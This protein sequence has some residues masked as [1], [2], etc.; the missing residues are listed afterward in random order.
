MRA[1][2]LDQAVAFFRRAVQSDP[3]KTEYKIALGRAMLAASYAHLERAKELEA[4]EQL[5][6]ARGEYRLASEYDPSN[7]S[8]AAKVAALDQ[9]IRYRAEA[10]RPRPPIDDMRARAADAEPCHRLGE[11]ALLGAR[12]CATF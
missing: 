2:N 6:A 7:R 11:S 10:A 1:G 3:D 5:E 9:I 4:Q 8:A 12:I